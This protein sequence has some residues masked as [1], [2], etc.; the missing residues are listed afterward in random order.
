MGNGR[1][2]SQALVDE[3]GDGLEVLEVDWMDISLARNKGGKTEDTSKETEGEGYDLILAVD[4]I[5]NESLVQPLV[6]TFAK[7][8]QNGGKTMVW[9]VIELRSSDVVSLLSRPNAIHRCMLT[10]CFPH[11]ISSS[12][13]SIPLFPS[14]FMCFT[15]TAH[16]IHGDLA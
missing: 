1:K 15:T 11:D 9:V 7:Y 6:D 13:P 4:C 3:D 8:C 2:H 12:L 14:S 10:L 5:F 16:I